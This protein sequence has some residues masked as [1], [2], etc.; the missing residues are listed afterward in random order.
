MEVGRGALNRRDYKG[1]PCPGPA[2]YWLSKL[3]D[4]MIFSRLHQ[5][6]LHKILVQERQENQRLQYRGPSYGMRGLDRRQEVAGME[7]LGVLT[8]TCHSEHLDENKA[9]LSCL[10]WR[11]P[12]RR[13]RAKAAGSRWKPDL[14][15][16]TTN[17]RTV[18]VYSTYTR[19]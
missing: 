19:A 15:P 12:N 1:A 9:K 7:S 16:A 11:H 10:E 8:S 4:I 2:E 13:S 18:Q 5:R 6:E 14:K 17:N 3:L